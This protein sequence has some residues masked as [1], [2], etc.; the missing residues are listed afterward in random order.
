MRTV[1]V[2]ILVFVSLMLSKLH[3]LDVKGIVAFGD[4]LTCNGNACLYAHTPAGICHAYPQGRFTDGPIW[5]EVFADKLGLPRPIPS[6][7]GGFNFA[8]GGAT[9]GWKSSPNI[10]NVGHQI[11]AYLKR[12]EGNADP[13]NLFVLWA[14]G[15]DIQ[16]KIIPINLVPNLK[17][18]ITTLARAGAKTFLIPNFPPLT[19]TPL[20]AEVLSHLGQ[21]LGKNFISFA[22]KAADWGIQVL[23][24]QLKSMLRKLE[25]SLNIKIYRLDAYTYFYVVRDHFKTMGLQ[26]K[27]LFIYDGFH[28]SAL[29]HALIAQEAFN[30]CNKVN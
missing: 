18:H 2:S 23:N 21:G 10:L 12:T 16:N 9:T 19:E 6:L 29:V 28:P 17:K 15:N 20:A 14:G 7:V 22:D 25:H 26:E 30:E 13:Q 8:Y 27:D 24:S 4:S 1:F 5:L 11:E 3:G